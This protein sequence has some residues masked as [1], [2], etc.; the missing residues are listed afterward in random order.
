MTTEWVVGVPAGA[1]RMELTRS[2]TDD[3]P[4][5]SIGEI[6]FTVTNPG[7]VEDRAVF[8]VVPGEGAKKSWFTVDEPQRRVP[9]GQSASFLIKVSVPVEEPAG[10]F[11]IQGR[12]YS[13]DTAPEESSRLSGRVSGEVEAIKIKPKKPWWLLAVAGLLVVVIGVVGWLVLRPREPETVPVPPLGGLS[14]EA[15]RTALTEA[16]L[17][18][19]SALRRHRSGATRTVIHQTVP[20]GTAVPPGSTVDVEIGVELAVPQLSSPANGRLLLSPKAPTLEWAAVPDAAFYAV[21]RE[22][23]VCNPV[24]N[25]PCTFELASIINV[26]GTTAAG[27]SPQGGKGVNGGVRWQVTPLDDFKDP[28]PT[29][30]YFSYRIVKRFK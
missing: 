21:R 15:A 16:G 27:L 10:A 9:G 2:G 4:G 3:S 12:V 11:W 8:E 14:E 22:M 13:A 30:G 26:T 24:Q 23:Q 29:S 20:D 7:P 19:G 1:E 17:Q 18:L 5:P 6:T 28:G 25:P